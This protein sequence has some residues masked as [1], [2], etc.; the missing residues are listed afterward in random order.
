MEGVR[1]IDK[2]D[3]DRYVN[4]QAE[5][6]TNCEAKMS[7]RNTNGKFRV[8][9]F[10]EEHNHD[11]HLLHTTHM[12]A[13]HRKLTEVQAQDIELAHNSG[14]TQ[15]ATYDPMGSQV[16]E[17]LIL[18]ILNWIDGEVQITNI[19]WADAR[20]VLD[21][22]YFGEVVSFD[23]TFCTNKA[24]RPLALFGGLNH[25]KRIVIFGAALLYD[26]TVACYEYMINM[27]D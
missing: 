27:V 7:I 14:L 23:T 18:D 4:H 22:G 5:T 17:G 26:E 13:C 11:L 19:F 25:H 16:G 6:R 2:R 12:L 20:M 8:Y 15:R 1:G 10:V 9:K 21:Y 24:N 3:D